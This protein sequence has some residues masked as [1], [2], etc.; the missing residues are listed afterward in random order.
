MSTLK[1]FDADGNAVYLNGEGAGT[2]GDPFNP[3]Q[4]VETIHRDQTTEDLSFFLV[5]QLDT[6]TID[7]NRALDDYAFSVTTTGVAP[8]AG[9]MACFKEGTKFL[10]AEILSVTP[11]T[12]N[13]Y[14]ITIDKPL[15]YAYTTAAV[16]ELGNKNLGSGT[17][18][19]TLASPIKF[20][21]GPSGMATG[22]Q[23][24]ICRMIIV[25][26]DATAFDDWTEFGNLATLTN[27]LMLRVENAG[28]RRETIGVYKSNL[29]LA[30]DAY[31]A[32]LFALGPTGGAMKVRMSFNGNDK[33]GVVKRLV[34]DDSDEFCMYVRDDITALDELFIKIQGHFTD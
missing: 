8:V 13:Q 23:W 28:G 27:G 24:D 33:R 20:R 32:D 30:S 31:D 16:G 18:A 29:D 14:T 25:C 9:N 17:S 6:F 12:G 7:T 2:A 11:I 10:Q 22:V 5:R 1:V 15:N 3:K 19:A 26:D 4:V 34:A 21:C